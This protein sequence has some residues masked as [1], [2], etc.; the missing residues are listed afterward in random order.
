MSE[1]QS[2]AEFV[3]ILSV[4]VLSSFMGLTLLGDNVNAIFASSS[5]QVS[6]FDP[7]NSKGQVSDAK[8]SNNRTHNYF[9]KNSQPYI[10]DSVVIGNYPV[11][12]LSDGSATFFVKGNEI[13]LSAQSLE[14]IN[15]VFQ[16]SGSSG[17]L[18]DIVSYMLQVNADD[19]KDQTIPVE[20]NFGSGTR[21]ANKGKDYSLSYHGEA[22]INTIAIQVGSHLILIQK[23]QD[24]N[25]NYD[26]DFDEEKNMTTIETLKKSQG[27]KII[28][29]EITENNH[30]KGTVIADNDPL[31]N[32]AKI[33][34]KITKTQNGYHFEDKQFNFNKDKTI[35]NISGTWEF[36]FNLNNKTTL[37]I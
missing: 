31:L 21:Y 7:F 17:D 13:R 32:G 27:L 18:I 8:I 19:Y 12:Q 11:D 30:F 24:L 5:H 2:L 6:Q 20:I 35:D 3:L 9:T 16:T 10:S 29:G 14:N 33:D 4:I 22:T 25:I 36:N 23:D 34:A 37:N 1:G 28:E 15:T 26:K